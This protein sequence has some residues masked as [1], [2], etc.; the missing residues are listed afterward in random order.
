MKRFNKAFLYFVVM[1]ALL[2]FSRPAAYGQDATGRVVG[3]VYDQ[4]GA[5]VAGVRVVV[6]NVA[7][8]MTRETVTDASGYYQVLALPVGDYTVSAEQKGF[9]SITTKPN[10]LEINESLKVDL[11]LEVGKA[12]ETVVV[13]SS[14]HAIETIN[15]TLASTVSDRVVE[16]MPLNGRN[17][18]N[19]ALLQPGVMPGDNMGNTSGGGATDSHGLT[20]GFSVGGGRTDSN[21]YILDGG[22]NNNLLNNAVV[23]NPNPDTVQ[24]FKVLTSNFGAEYGRSSGGIITVVTKSGTNEFHGTAFEYNRNTDYNANDFFSNLNGQPR[25]NLKRNQYGGTLGGPVKKDKLFFFVSYEGQKQN[26]LQSSGSTPVFTTAEIQNGDFSKSPHVAD[27]I[28]FL[29]ANPFFQSNPALAAQGIIDPTKFDSV[30]KK[31]IA[32]GLVP[33]NAT[34]TANF[35]NAAINNPWELTAKTDYE[36]T[37]KD[38]FTVTLGRRHLT[39]LLPGPGSIPGFGENFLNIREFANVAYTRILSPNMLNEF[40]ATFQRNDNK[41]DIPASKAPIPS[42]LG[43]NVT[44]DNPSGPTQIDLPGLTIGFSGQGPTRLVDNTYTFTDAFSWTRG[45]HTMK[46]GATFSAYQD[47]QIFDFFV[48]GALTY[49]RFDANGNPGFGAGD[50]F[51]NFLVGVPNNYF[52]APAAPS[53]IR[54]KANYY[55]G[56]DEWHVR[57]DLT[58]TLGVRYEYSTPKS[59]TQGRLFN[60]VPGAQ[61]TVFPNAPVGLVFPGDKASPGASNFP[62]R[63]NFAPR[64]GFAWQPFK[65]GKTGV[66]GGAGLFY[67]ILKAEDNFQFNGQF[68][69]AATANLFYFQSNLPATA[70]ANYTFASD[71]F[72]SIGAPNPFPSKPVDHNISFINNVGTFGGTGVFFVNPHLRTPYT[73]QYNLSIEHEIAQNTTVT[74]AYVGSLSRK[75]TGLEDINPFDPATLNSPN[76]QRVLNETPGNFPAFTNTNPGCSQNPPVNCVL[77]AGF[78]PNVPSGSFGFMPEFTNSPRA[79]YN[80]MNLSLTRR[81]TNTRFLGTTYFTLAYT[82]AHEID[83]ASGFRQNNSSIPTFAPQVFR[84]SGDFDI[85]QYVTFSGGWDLP[86]NRGPQRLVKGWSIYPILTWRTGFPFTVSGPLFTSNTNPGPA[87]DGDAGLALSDLSQPIQYVN[88]HSTQPVA[89]QTGNF[90]FNPADFSQN[91]PTAPFG[92]SA[93]N[94]FRLPGRTNLDLSLSKVTPLWKERVSL[95][96]RVDAFNIFNHTQFQNVDNNILDFGTTF[97]QMTTTYDPRILQL[98]AHIRF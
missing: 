8:K 25:P 91:T 15:A 40:H 33:S 32:A 86:F 70:T 51:A 71:P 48:N 63:D 16:D 31:Y 34:G 6:T 30:A 5:V 20:M 93:R 2:A 19:L 76:P 10:H 72:G 21:T 62:V 49:S 13:E 22:S 65:D 98:G 14:A 58:L 53:N 78:N 45:A 26:E 60:V 47:N 1:M 7:T 41:Q 57:N 61:S 46:F 28:S 35:Q 96:I 52:Q 83:S 64:F 80:A 97:G 24:E 37:A 79:N 3:N 59:D 85:R 73:Y 55:Y 74:A 94:Q 77:P 27:V 66:R 44:P 87:G 75:L 88:P 42:A 54:T 90:L 84:A 82:W 29:Q 38:H 43:I 67:D 81:A 17:T 18:L 23:Y 9:T 92:T 56:Q 69:F 89:G 4:T 95:E 50:A 36:M 11:K 68:P 12:T 39:E